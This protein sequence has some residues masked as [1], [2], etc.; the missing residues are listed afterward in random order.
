MPRA[1]RSEGGEGGAGGERQRCS[2]S[3]SAACGHIVA[4]SRRLAGTRPGAGDSSVTDRL[5]AHSLRLRVSDGHTRPSSL[6]T[7]FAVNVQD[8]GYHKPNAVSSAVVFEAAGVWG[9]IRAGTHPLCNQPRSFRCIDLVCTRHYAS[10][11][12]SVVQNY[13]PH[14]NG[15]PHASDT[16]HQF[17]PPAST[18]QVSKVAKSTP[19][20]V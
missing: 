2:W 11:S 13:L 14:S 20:D 4:V 19:P 5:S 18:P 9:P 12:F 1:T 10:S 17:A 15:Q 3:R 16:G 6:W 8:I 7:P